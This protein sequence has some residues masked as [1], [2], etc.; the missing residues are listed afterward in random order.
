ME[1]DLK[2][3]EQKKELELLQ[4]QM[5]KKQNSTDAEKQD[6]AKKFEQL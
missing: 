6:L 5:S 2:Y 1:A 4:A 3:E